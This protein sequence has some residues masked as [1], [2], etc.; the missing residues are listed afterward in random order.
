MPARDEAKELLPLARVSRGVRPGSTTTVPVPTRGRY[1][2]DRWP[3]VAGL[4]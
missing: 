3:T 2:A 1:C 4:K